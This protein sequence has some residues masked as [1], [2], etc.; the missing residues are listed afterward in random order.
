M[1]V[2]GCMYVR[3]CVCER[4]LCVRV[5]MCVLGAMKSWFIFIGYTQKTKW[6]NILKTWD[7]DGIWNKFGYMEWRPLKDG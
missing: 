7:S 3:I 5:Y 4:Q 6:G 1:C 2:S